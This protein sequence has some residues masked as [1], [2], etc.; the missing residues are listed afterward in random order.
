MMKLFGGFVVLALLIFSANTAQSQWV[1]MLRSMFPAKLESIT[2]QSGNVIDDV[3]IYVSWGKWSVQF[4]PE[5][6]IAH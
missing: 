6:P 2:L 1:G 4:G 5:A 3:G